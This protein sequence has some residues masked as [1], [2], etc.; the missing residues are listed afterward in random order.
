MEQ[1]ANGFQRIVIEDKSW[2]F[3][4][5]PRDSVWAA[6]RDEL[7]QRIKQKINTEKFLVSII[8]SVNGIHSLFDVPK[9]TTYNHCSSQM[10]L[11]P[12]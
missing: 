7:P 3:P 4:Y 9:R 8:W 2:F 11:C 10:L 1:K 12:V 6:S 5:Y